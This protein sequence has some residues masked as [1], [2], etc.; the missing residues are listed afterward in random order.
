MAE[1]QTTIQGHLS[2]VLTDAE[3]NVKDT[4]EVD[5][6]VTTVGKNNVAAQLLAAPGVATP[7]HL[8]IGTGAVAAAVGDTTLGTEV[9]RMALTSKTRSTNVVTMVG[10]FAAGT[11]TGTIT[12][13]GP[14]NAAT[15]GDLYARVVFAG[16]SK[17]AADT[18]KITYTLTVG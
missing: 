2:I 16:V 7:T 12:E 14:L 10:D 18:L 9:A 6:L 4:R 11:G 8:A 13:A 17:L 1:S 15:T 5:N 3:G